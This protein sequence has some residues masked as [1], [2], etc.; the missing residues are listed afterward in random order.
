MFL[1]LIPAYAGR[2]PFGLPST[3]PLPAHPR[4]RGADAI[5]LSTA[6]TKRGSSPLTRGGRVGRRGLAAG[7]GLIPAYAGRTRRSK[8]THA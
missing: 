4:L 8:A 7:Q 6:P 5:S 1:G 3:F 2:T